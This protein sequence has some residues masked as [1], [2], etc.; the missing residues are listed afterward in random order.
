MS[1]RTPAVERFWAKVDKASGCWWWTAYRN[2]WGYGVF[3]FHARKHSL[4]HRV[5]WEFTNGA[6]PDGLLVLHRCDN[7]ACVNPDHLF[8]GTNQDNMDDMYKKGRQRHIRGEDRTDAKLTEKSVRDV[9]RRQKEG[10][11]TH[12]QLATEYGVSRSTVSM[13][14][15]GDTWGWLQ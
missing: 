9:R 7:P 14:V 4:A 11:V 6:I 15:R 10:N 12:R 13:A 5:A 1:K 8:L 3:G 2:Q